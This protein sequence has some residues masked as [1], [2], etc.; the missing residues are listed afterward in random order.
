MGRTS[1]VIDIRA[2]RL[3]VDNVGIGPQRIEYRLGDVPETAVGTVQTSLDTLERVDSEAD[4]IAHVAVAAGHIVHRAA[5]VLPVSE[6]QL[7]PVL[8][9]HMELPVDVVLHQQQGLLGHL[10]V[11]AVDQLDAVVVERVMAGGDHNAAVKIIHAGNV[12]H[13][14]GSGDVEQEGIRAGGSQTCNQTILEHIGAAAGVLANDDA[15][16]L[17]VAIAFTQSVVIPAE[18]ATYLIGLQSE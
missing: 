17:I 7:R 16:R 11:V 6:G 18:E 10:F 13:A 9:E 5:N 14:G 8:V 12:C 1:I 15:C 3:V 2:V 4:Q